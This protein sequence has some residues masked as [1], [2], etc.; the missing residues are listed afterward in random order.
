MASILIAEDEA[1]IAA[2]VEKG[3]AA[4]GF[5]TRVAATGRDALDLVRALGGIDALRP[6]PIAQTARDPRLGRQIRRLGPG[7]GRERNAHPQHRGRYLVS[8]S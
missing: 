3:L 1:R 7:C 6:Q 4:A 5:S 2:F 8:P